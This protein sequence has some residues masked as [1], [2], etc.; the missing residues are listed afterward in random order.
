MEALTIFATVLFII[1]L[2]LF[3]LGLIVL[4]L[5]VLKKVALFLLEF[6]A[7]FAL[8]LILPIVNSLSWFY[9]LNQSKNR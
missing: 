8:I 6:I 4:I 3:L 7:F 9:A 2:A 5:P 1:S